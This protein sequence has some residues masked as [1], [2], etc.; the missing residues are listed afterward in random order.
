MF[1]FQGWNDTEAQAQLGSQKS[2]A[3]IIFMNLKC[4]TIP[5]RRSMP[6]LTSYKGLIGQGF[7]L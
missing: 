6:T 4:D 1:F 3:T 5:G 7:L 2:G